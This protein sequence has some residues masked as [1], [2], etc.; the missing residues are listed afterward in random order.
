MGSLKD[1]CVG[2][3]V[4]YRKRQ[5]IAIVA[6]VSHSKIDL[7]PA[8]LSGLFPTGEILDGCHGL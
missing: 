6:L 1:G 3:G 5:C 7:L 8:E 4:Y 2:E